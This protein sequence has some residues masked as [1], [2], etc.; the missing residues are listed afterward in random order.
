[1]GARC[2]SNE[3]DYSHTCY[4]MKNLEKK[5]LDLQM[6]NGFQE[7]RMEFDL[8]FLGIENEP[9]TDDESDMNHRGKSTDSPDARVDI[10]RV[11]CIR[12]KS[13]LK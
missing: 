3:E 6:R 7:G 12:K 5:H 13:L 4:D 2:S 1:M 8:P 10:T 9:G 11:S